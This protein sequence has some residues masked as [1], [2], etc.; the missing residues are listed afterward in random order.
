MKRSCCSVMG[1]SQLPCMIITAVVHGST[2][3][4]LLLRNFLPEMCIVSL[5]LCPVKCLPQHLH[6]HACPVPFFS[7]FKFICGVCIQVCLQ[8]D[9]NVCPT[10]SNFGFVFL[11][12]CFSRSREKP[13]F[14]DSQNKLCLWHIGIS[15]LSQLEKNNLFLFT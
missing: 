13:D 6:V 4:S 14:D 12:R 11:T 9:S 7:P 10:I 5:C 3:I 2:P 8:L 15:R 1:T